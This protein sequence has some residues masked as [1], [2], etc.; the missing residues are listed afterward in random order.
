MQ[1]NTENR[2]IS[3]MQF[4]N[5]LP[6]SSLIQAFKCSCGRVF[7]IDDFSEEYFC[8][9]GNILVGEASGLIG[10]NLPEDSRDIQPSRICLKCF[11][12]YFSNVVNSIINKE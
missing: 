8:I 6:G 5:V 12:E 2:E 9:Y 1:E 4:D 11:L 3:L 10:G 7:E